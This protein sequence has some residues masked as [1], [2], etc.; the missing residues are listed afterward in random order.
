ME[1]ELLHI[2]TL[3]I[4]LLKGL[5]EASSFY[6]AA[7][8]KCSIIPDNGKFDNASLEQMVREV[9]ATTVDVADQLTDS[10]YHYDA[11]EKIFELAG[12]FEERVAAKEM[13][14]AEKA[15]E[16]AIKKPHK[17]LGGEAI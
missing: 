4:R 3:W 7:F 8:M 10:V 17:C 9:N 14:T 6:P 5:E 1:P 11:D 16:N 12:K 15:I 2:R 13:G